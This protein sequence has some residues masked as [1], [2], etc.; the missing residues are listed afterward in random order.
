[1]PFRMKGWLSVVRLADL[2]TI[3][4]TCRVRPLT[5]AQLWTV[6]RFRNE[7]TFN[8]AYLRDAAGRHPYFLRRNGEVCALFAFR[9]CLEAASLHVVSPSR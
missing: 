9:G 5:D 1:M 3:N 7:M 4:E 8:D 6:M 2:C